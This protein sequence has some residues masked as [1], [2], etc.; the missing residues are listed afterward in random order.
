M[1]TDT[2]I[3]AIKPPKQ[4]QDEYPDHRVTGLRVRVGTSGKKTWTLRKRVGSKTIN[5]KLGTY[6]AM[7]LSQA[8]D[9]AEK[10][11]QAIE[12]DGTT[13]A[14][15]RTF[16]QVAEHWIESVAKPKH[17]SWRYQERRLEMHV[18]PHWGDRKIATITADDVDR[19]LE[20]IEGK[21][22][23]NEVL[24]TIKTVF[25]YAVKR[26]WIP[27]SPAAPV[28]KT[29]EEKPRDR[30]LD[31]AEIARVWR[32]SE[33]LG[34][35]FEQF[36]KALLLT[37]QRRTEVA[38]MRWTDVNLEE[39]TWLL[40][41]E[42]TKSQRAH[43]VPLSRPVVNML[44]KLPRLGD[45]VFTTNGETHIS[46]YA[47]AKSRL[48]GF[49]AASGEQLPRWVLHDLRRTVGYHL[50]RMGVA[51]ELRG[52]IFNHAL[53]GVTDQRY[54]P[55]DYHEPKRQALEAW[56]AEVCQTVNGE[57]SDNVVQMNG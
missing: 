45:F 49:I 37:G 29:V 2:K 13:D 27:H 17:K 30:W 28:E 21:S 7:K 4:G 31:K 40:E 25:R 38:S 18:T 5:R 10:V 11:L 33:L 43:L 20:T 42:A 24:K 15:E 22:L 32:A 6:P 53:E 56:A 47:K 26:R 3:A 44:G 39:G 41:A 36:I 23:P 48:D 54:N 9:A 57:R 34:F 50:A 19:L 12:R 14:L 1:L 46:G 51:K 16:R 8:R 52:R 35:P 55:Y